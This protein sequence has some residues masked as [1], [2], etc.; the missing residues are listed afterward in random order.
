MHNTRQDTRQNTR[1]FGY[2]N[3]TFWSSHPT[4]LDANPTFYYLIYWFYSTP[5]FLL[6]APPLNLPSTLWFDPLRPII[7][8]PNS[9][10]W[11]KCLVSRFTRQVAQKVSYCLSLDFF[12][13][14]SATCQQNMGI[15]TKSQFG[16][17][18]HSVNRIIVEHAYLVQLSSNILWV[19][20]ELGAN[21]LN[22][23][24]ILV[25]WF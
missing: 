23:R 1:L 8:V 25:F 21:I 11:V 9:E 20:Y 6:P 12:C 22:S 16:E 10:E 18:L 15:Y 17:K 5:D 7:Q 3:P 14:S 13:I 24:Y 4:R 2:P 19:L